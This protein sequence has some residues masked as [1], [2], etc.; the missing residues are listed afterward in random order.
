MKK[1]ALLALCVFSFLR[2]ELFSQ[3][4]FSRGEE[5]FLANR[6]QEALP[7]LEAAFAED[8]AHV[9][10]AL[11]LGTVY[12][13]LNRNDEAIAVFRKILP[14]SGNQS[15]LVAF[16]L[17]NVYFI[18]GESVFAEQFYTQ[19]V[20]ADP[21]YAPA[22]LNRANARIKNGDLRG[23]IPDYEQYLVLEPRSPKRA[24][25]ESL[26]Q[27]IHNEFRLEEEKRLAAEAE[28]RAA[29][30]RRQRLLEEVSTSLQAAA[31]ETQGLSAG[32]ENVLGYEGEFELE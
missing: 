32:T 14:R 16:N 30:E 12:I 7:L 11:Y 9:K 29:A 22:W 24:Q 3:N 20:Q 5:F 13:Q 31:E 4:S 17:G 15:A 27:F 1:T 25:I 28:A 8:P 2:V 21:A 18:K 10:A 23:A 26:I 6:P 19:A